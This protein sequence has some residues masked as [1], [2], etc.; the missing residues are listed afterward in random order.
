MTDDNRTAVT[1]GLF[2]LV[3]CLWLL[4]PGC[5][6][7]THQPPAGELRGVAIQHASS[8]NDAATWDFRARVDGGLVT[9]PSW[10]A[11]LRY[12][13]RQVRAGHATWWLADAPESCTD[14]E[15]TW[16]VVRGAR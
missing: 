16:C 10:V 5:G 15:A 7:A 1:L 12:D 13:S 9:T 4:A 11:D 6:G 14:E 8:T 3:L 2:L